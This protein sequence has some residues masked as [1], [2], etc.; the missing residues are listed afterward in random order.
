MG[1]LMLQF[2]SQ[3]PRPS[4]RPMV[5]HV[6]QTEIYGKRPIKPRGPSML[7]TL[8]AS[9]CIAVGHLKDAYEGLGSGLIRFRPA[10][11][12]IHV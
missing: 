8:P 6:S 4:C 1:R 5:N 12:K 9:V 2:H 7:S 10:I 11:Y 3:D